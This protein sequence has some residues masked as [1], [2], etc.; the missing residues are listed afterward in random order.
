MPSP[1]APSA[2]NWAPNSTG[3]AALVGAM[4]NDVVVAAVT[5]TVRTIDAWVE[6]TNLKN[7]GHGVLT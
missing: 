1:R 3:N 6:M 7:H 4:G 2:G 5:F